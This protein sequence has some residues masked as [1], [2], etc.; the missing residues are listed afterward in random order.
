MVELLQIGVFVGYAIECLCDLDS[1]LGPQVLF[2]DGLADKL[3]AN[4]IPT[5]P[6]QHQ[7]GPDPHIHL[8]GRRFLHTVLAH[9]GG[10]YPLGLCCEAWPVLLALLE[11]L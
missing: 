7:Y 2:P 1:D 3:H 10:N 9:N 8:D 4:D 11:I 5:I 6:H